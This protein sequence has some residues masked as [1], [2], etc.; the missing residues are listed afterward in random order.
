MM[1]PQGTT[2]RESLATEGPDNALREIK[3]WQAIMDYLRNLPV[4]NNEK[5]PVIPVD[6][7]AAEIRA[8]NIPENSGGKV[9]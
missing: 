9:I 1:L 7:R 6:R 8:I 5:L 2:D 4:K 3:E